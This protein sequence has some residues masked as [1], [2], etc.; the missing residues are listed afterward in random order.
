MTFYLGTHQPQ[1][2]GRVDFPLF[3]SRARLVARKAFPR[4]ACRWA[5]DSGGFTQLNLHGRW[6][7]EPARYADEAAT[8]ADRIGRMDWAAIQDWMCEPFVLEKTGKSILEH[9]ELTV[10][11]YLDL[12][13]LAPGTPWAPVLQ[14]W[15]V[16]DYLAHHAMYRS[17]GVDLATLPVVGVGSVCRRQATSE[18]V[19]IFR[20][21]AGLGVRAHGFG[22]KLKGLAGCSELLASSD[23]MA[24]SYCGR[25]NSPLPGHTH[26]NCANCL[27]YAT[28]WRDKV[29]RLI[30]GRADREAA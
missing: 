8:Y 17:A 23:S 7:V 15:K 4:A 13:A 2:L 26:K 27:E 6:D 9:Q 21:V 3:V 11:S 5:L 14:G 18:C 1:W 28:L 29:M 24:W 10:R 19:D 16:D 22:L 30:S 20:A 12:R 25:R